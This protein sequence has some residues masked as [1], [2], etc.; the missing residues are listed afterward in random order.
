MSFS[1][2]SPFVRA[3]PG[4][5]LL[6]FSVPAAAEAQ[7]PNLAQVEA[8]IASGDVAAARTGMQAW[9][10]ARGE[11]LTSQDADR[12]RA[13]LLRA[14]MQQEIESARADYL[15]L[16]LEHPTS[17]EAAE[18]LLRL[19]QSDVAAGEQARAI[20]YLSRLHT[21]HPASP[22]AAVASLWL[23]RAHLRASDEASA[24]AALQKGLTTAASPGARELLEAEQPRACPRL[25]L[26]APSTEASTSGATP[27]AAAPNR[28]PSPQRTAP[29]AAAAARAAGR[30]AVQSGAFRD[31]A[32]ARTVAVRL[33][34]QGH[35]P[36]IV[37]IGTGTL[38]RVRVGKWATRA[39]AKAV[40]A[41]LNTNGFESLVVDDVPD[42][43]IIEP[44]GV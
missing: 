27:R 32:G 3:L 35:Q 24:C 1:R 8:R 15:T 2:M 6:A 40:A 22:H 11:K 29:A 38:Y 26:S 7:T 28:Q 30:F 36:R 37:R 41:T 18:A 43:E 34:A 13:L 42:E 4:A 5:A 31:L 14:R 33:R 19:G 16:V 9:W 10:R 17:S 20:R 12:A 44:A 25:V 39:D 23:A 21:D